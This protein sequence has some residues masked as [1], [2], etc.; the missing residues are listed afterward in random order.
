MM[1]LSVVLVLTITGCA[2]QSE[3][4][5]PSYSIPPVPSPPEIEAEQ[6]ECLSDSVYADI[7]E[8]DRQL[9]DW[10]LEQRAILIEMKENDS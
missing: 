1:F 8:R 4:I 6:L 7:I 5:V 2:T 10:G 3:Y 9:L